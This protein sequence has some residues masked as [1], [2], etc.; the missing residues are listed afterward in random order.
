MHVVQKLADEAPAMLGVAQDAP[1]NG[2]KFLFQMIR[3][4]VAMKQREASR[5]CMP[6][7]GSQTLDKQTLA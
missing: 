5:L 6:I 4:Q 2:K 7:S 1:P 3:R